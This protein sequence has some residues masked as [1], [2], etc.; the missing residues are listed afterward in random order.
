MSAFDFLLRSACCVLRSS[1]PSYHALRTVFFLDIGHWTSLLTPNWSQQEPH[2]P[3]PDLRIQIITATKMMIPSPFII[4]LPLI[5]S[6]KVHYWLFAPRK[7]KSVVFTFLT[8]QLLTL[9]VVD[10][11][12]PDGAR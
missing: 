7:A 6:Q 2:V 11:G 12:A 8:N 10:L 3:P 1:Y 4:P 5:G 9:Q